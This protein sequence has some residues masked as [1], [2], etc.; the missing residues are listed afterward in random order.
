MNAISTTQRSRRLRKKL[1]LEEFQ[2][3]GF[4]I[5]ITLTPASEE[6]L[7]VAMDAWIRFVEANAWG[8][9]GGGNPNQLIGFVTKA[10]GGS[11][12][13][14]DIALVKTWGSEQAWVEETV[15]G[16]LTDAWYD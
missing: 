13:E 16:E 4:D 3:L 7:D 14:A 5:K 1:K 10:R 11:L 6:T 12:T 15:V 8:F 9:G 2:E